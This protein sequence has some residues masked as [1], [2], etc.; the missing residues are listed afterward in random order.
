LSKIEPNKA[1][2]PDGIPSRLLKETAHQMAPPL[3]FIFQSSLDQGQLPQDWKSVN[4]TP[5]CK[6]RQQNRSSKLSAHIY[7]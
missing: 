2:V 7:L 1:A 3:T 5:I 4:I 6:K